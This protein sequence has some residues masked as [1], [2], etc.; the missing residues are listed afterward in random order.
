[1][2]K[3][4]EEI[5]ELMAILKYFPADFSTWLELGDRYFSLADF[6]VDIFLFLVSS[7]FPCLTVNPIPQAAAHCYEELVL[8]DPHTAH[9]HTKL[10]EAYHTIGGC[11]LSSSPL[12][13]QYQY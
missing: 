13:R 12:H 9:V 1:M 11:F 7:R 8:L 4:D 3:V 2:G 5:N 10:A 6:E